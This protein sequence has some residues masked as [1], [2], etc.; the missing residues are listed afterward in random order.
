[1]TQAEGPVDKMTLL[2][3]I[4]NVMLVFMTMLVL[5]AIIMFVIMVCWARYV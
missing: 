2:N 1:M 3:S 4:R 5:V